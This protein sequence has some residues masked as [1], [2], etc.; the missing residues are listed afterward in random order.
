MVIR[1]DTTASISLKFFGLGLILASLLSVEILKF[2][3][4]S[5]RSIKVIGLIMLFLH[6]YAQKTENFS[7]LKFTIRNILSFYSIFLLINIIISAAF[8]TILAEWIFQVGLLDI[9]LTPHTVIAAF[10]FFFVYSVAGNEIM[11]KAYIY[12]LSK[13]GKGGP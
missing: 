11:R 8:V 9:P 3:V 4:L 7:N 6:V 12:Q 10:I 2:D 5:A 13:Q 1:R